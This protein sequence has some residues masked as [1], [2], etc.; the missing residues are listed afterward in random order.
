MVAMSEQHPGRDTYRRRRR[1]PAL[2]LLVV[3]ALVVAFVWSRVLTTTT[4]LTGAAPCPAPPPAAGAPAGVTQ[5]AIG[6]TVDATELDGS[7]PVAPGSF[8][9]RVL[10]AN[11]QRGQAALVAAELINSY[12][13]VGAGNAFDNDPVYYDQS[14]QCVGQIRFGPNGLAQ[15]RT[16][17]LAVPCA[18]LVQD[19]REDTGVELALGTT[20]GDVNPSPDATS[21][22]D[23]VRAATPD[24]PA[25]L[26]PTI[27]AS[28]GTARC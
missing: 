25:Q 6:T 19:A 3:L 27:L 20:F 5:P 21:V 8:P 14:M 16:M 1:V 2:V 12:G 28:A 22:L 17:H 18:E 10:N 13:F 26:D 9:M 11:G 23:A 15:A 24:A 7:T 4:T